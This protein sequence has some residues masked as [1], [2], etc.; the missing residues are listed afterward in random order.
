M[1]RHSITVPDLD[2][3]GVTITLSAWLASVGDMVME[4]DRV[5]EILAGNVT[6]DVESPVTGI[7]AEKLVAVDDRL[8]VDQAI[9]VVVSRS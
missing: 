8:N 5:A 4:G 3:P 6:V 1:P 7:L 2:L 9:A